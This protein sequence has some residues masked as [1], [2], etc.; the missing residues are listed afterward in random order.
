LQGERVGPGPGGF[1]SPRTRG[2]LPGEPG[3]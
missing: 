3:L 1:A 2:W